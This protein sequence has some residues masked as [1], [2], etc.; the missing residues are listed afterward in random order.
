MKKLLITVFLLASS[1]K[2]FATCIVIYIADN[3][4]IYVAADSKRTFYFAEG[5][6]SETVCKI[7]NVG[8]NY[9]A[10]SGIDD[11][12]LVAE[13][14][15]ALTPTLN[16]D[17]AIRVFGETMSA[18]YDKLVTDM[19]SY[20]PDKVQHFLNDGLGQVSF[21]GF[22]NGK[23]KVTNVEFECSLGVNGR[24]ITKY[25]VK[26]I[27]EITVIGLSADIANASYKDMPS[28]YTRAHNPAL[29]VQKLVEIEVKFRPKAVGGP[30]DVL[31]L[32]PGKEI[33]IQKNETAAVY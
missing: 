1:M 32:Q 24:V 7:H 16:I 21:F 12:A 15:K 22:Y 2:C 20:Y 27:K 17:S 28:G 8:A 4:H 30:I 5:E 31:E 25:T 29:Y 14:N 19:I 33:W 9:F 26:Q 23:P 3:G 10:V 18:H 6:R 11:S 13:A